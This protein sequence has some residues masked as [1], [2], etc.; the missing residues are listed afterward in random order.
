MQRSLWRWQCIAIGI[1]A[2]FPRHFQVP[3]S[4]PVS[5]RKQ[6]DDKASLTNEKSSATDPRSQS[7]VEQ[8]VPVLTTTEEEKE[9]KRKKANR[10]VCLSLLLD[11]SVNLFD[12]WALIIANWHA[13]RALT[14]MYLRPTSA[15]SEIYSSSKDKPPFTT[16]HR[17]SVN[18]FT[19]PLKMEGLSTGLPLS[20]MQLLHG[21]CTASK[22]RKN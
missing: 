12:P 22:T 14:L 3:Q 19:N 5:L 16:M 20:K 7:P 17:T 4:P 21:P 2:L 8:T 10:R 18:Y 15:T 9:K 11:L 1:V 13:L 6:H